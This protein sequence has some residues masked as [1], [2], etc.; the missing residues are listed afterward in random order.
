[1]KGKAAIER[2]VEATR[3]LDALRQAVKDDGNPRVSVLRLALSRKV[4][5]ERMLNGGQLGQARRILTSMSTLDE[6]RDTRRE[7]DCQP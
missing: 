1:V 4:E 3:E 6:T 5:S 7:E 2:Y